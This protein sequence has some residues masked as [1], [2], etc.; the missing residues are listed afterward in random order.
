MIDLHNHVLPGVDDGAPNL[1]AA[2]R[3]L[4]IAAGQGITHVCCTPHAN[5]RADERTDRLYQSVFLQLRAAAQAA[6]IPVELGLA[7]EIMLGADLLNVLRL[8]FA[9]FRAGRKYFL[10]E[11][12]VSTP[13]AIMLNAV[14]V[15]VRSG[16]TPVLAHTER[17][18]RMLTERSLPQAVRAA[19]AVLTIDAGS[20]LGQFGP[21]AAK[22]AKQLLAWDHIDILCSDAHDDADHGFCLQAGCA[23]AAAIVGAA[24]ARQMVLD[25]P[26]RIWD[27][28]PWPQNHGING[29]ENA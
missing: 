18:A 25:N 7:A 23:A 16:Y 15:A 28:Q 9:T 6:R 29:N 14:K 4:K 17:F 27:G 20:L 3:M 11:F 12:P 5:D 21:V 1:E 8:P 2:L 26:R 19:G 24:R 10:L 22:R 13:Y